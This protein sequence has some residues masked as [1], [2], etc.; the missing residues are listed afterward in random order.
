MTDQGVMAGTSA[1]AV[2]SDDGR[3]QLM[4]GEIKTTL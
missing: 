2:Q 1:E 4:N 3:K